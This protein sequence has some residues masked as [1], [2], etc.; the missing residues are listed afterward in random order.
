MVRAKHNT[1]TS[2][3][4]FLFIERTQCPDSD[5]Y[6]G[7]KK[8]AQ[9]SQRVPYSEPI[10]LDPGLSVIM[11]YRCK[12]RSDGEEWCQRILDHQGHGQGAMLGL[13][14]KK[15]EKARGIKERRMRGGVSGMR[16]ANRMTKR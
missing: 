12:K 9:E 11:S 13:R 10:F 6:M 4:I 16:R 7:M 3:N 14:R 5:Q 2:A 1:Q 8:K 15:N